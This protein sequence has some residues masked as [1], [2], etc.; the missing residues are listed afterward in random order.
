MFGW[1]LLEALTA[2]SC[3][4]SYDAG[5]HLNSISGDDLFVFSDRGH[6]TGT[7]ETKPSS[8]GLGAKVRRSG[9]PSH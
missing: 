9:L 5:E 7:K 3:A 4:G 8:E 2:F 1:V 6:S